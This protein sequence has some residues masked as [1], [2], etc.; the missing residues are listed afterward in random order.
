MAVS[1]IGGGDETTIRKAATLENT[2]YRL[3]YVI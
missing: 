1:F 3:S 2:D